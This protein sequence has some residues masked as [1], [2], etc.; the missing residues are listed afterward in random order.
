MVHF[1]WANRTIDGK[2]RAQH[3]VMLMVYDLENANA[4]YETTGNKR[5]KQIESVTLSKFDKGK[6]FHTWVSFIL[7]DRQDISMS[8]YAG[9]FVF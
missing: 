5:S 4:Y 9:S 7:E 6:T 3:Q 2:V 8:M 1:S